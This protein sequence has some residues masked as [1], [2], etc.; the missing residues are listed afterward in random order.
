MLVCNSSDEVTS[1]M[2]KFVKGHVMPPE[3]AN[4][5]RPVLLN[6]WEATYFN[7]DLEK[8][9]EL[10]QKAKAAGIEL[11]V[12]DDGWFGHRDD[13]TSSLAAETT[14]APV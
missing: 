8:L 4:K 14:I 1:E 7:F 12:L 13:D 11:F 2:H 5:P 9:T 3:F 10:L 6:N